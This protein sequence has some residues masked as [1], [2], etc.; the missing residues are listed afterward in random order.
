MVSDLIDGLRLSFPL[1]KVGDKAD[2][3]V[4]YGMAYEDKLFRG[5]PPIQ[6]L[7]ISWK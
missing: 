3:I 5:I 7:F 2:I 4:P 6:L 1:L